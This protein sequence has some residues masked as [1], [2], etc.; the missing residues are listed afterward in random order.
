M[1]RT[2]TIGR[3]GGAWCSS[4]FKAGTKRPRDQGTKGLGTK[5]P[6]GFEVTRLTADIFFG[7]IAMSQI[8]PYEKF[9]DGRPLDVILAAT[10]SAIGE[11]LE[12]LGPKQSTNPAHAKWSAAEIVSH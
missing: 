8:N 2:R 9:L 10:P 5:G 4:I 3:H 7:D 6:R 12:I 11:Y 1:R